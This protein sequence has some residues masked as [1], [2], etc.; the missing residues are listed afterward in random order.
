MNVAQD[1]LELPITDVLI[2]GT[3]RPTPAIILE[4]TSEVRKR[5]HSSFSLSTTAMIPNGSGESAQQ[6][7]LMLRVLEVLSK[8]IRNITN[9]LSS[10]CLHED[11]VIILPPNRKFPRSVKD[12]VMRYAVK[13]QLPTGLKESVLPV[14]KQSFSSPTSSIVF[15]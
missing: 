11:K 9:T 4:T 10:S 8:A 12:V 3:S 14:G 5:V 7:E 2:C 15:S 13:Y 1:H 6:P